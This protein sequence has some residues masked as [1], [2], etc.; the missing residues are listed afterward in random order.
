MKTK[1]THI[2]LGI[3]PQTQEML[4]Y[5]LMETGELRSHILRTAVRLGLEQMVA[6][7]KR[8]KNILEQTH[9]L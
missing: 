8:S 7:H 1:S 9:R 3:Y 5:L 4:D 2:S 6:T